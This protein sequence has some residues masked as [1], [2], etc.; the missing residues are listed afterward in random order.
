MSL[1][2]NKLIILSERKQ[3]K[4]NIVI[5]FRGEFRDDILFFILFCIYAINVNYVAIRKTYKRSKEILS[6]KNNK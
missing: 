6:I 3:A 2:V 4:M 1:S 5:L